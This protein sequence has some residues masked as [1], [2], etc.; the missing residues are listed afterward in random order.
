MNNFMVKLKGNERL[1]NDIESVFIKNFYIQNNYEDELNEKKKNI[2]YIL[3]ESYVNEYIIP[4]LIKEEGDYYYVLCEINLSSFNE[5]SDHSFNNILNLEFYSSHIYFEDIEK[6]LYKIKTNVQNKKYKEFNIKNKNVLLLHGDFNYINNNKVMKK[7]GNKMKELYNYIKENEHNLSDCFNNMEGSFILIYVQYENDKVN[8]IFFND[9]F[10]KKSFMFFHLNNSIVLT[11]MYGHFINYDFN[12]IRLNKENYLFDHNSIKEEFNLISHSDII[13]KK[14]FTNDKII[15][16]YENIKVKDKNINSI[17]EQIAINIRPHFIYNLLIQKDKVILKNIKKTNCI[18]NNYYEWNNKNISLKE[19]FQYILNFFEKNNFFDGFNKEEQ[20]YL[21][22]TIEY[23]VNE[24][25]KYEKVD[26]EKKKRY[27]NNENIFLET[28]INNIF[29]NLHMALLNNVIKK[30]I[31]ELFECTGENEIDK[32]K[33]DESMDYFFKK[34]I[35]EN[36]KEDEKKKSVGILFSGGIDSTLLTIITIKNFFRFY[37]NGYIELINVAF[38]ENAVD[39]Y[40]SLLS[41]EKIINLFPYYDIRLVFIDVSPDELIKYE[42]IIYSLIS[43]NNTTMDYNISSALF[44]ANIGRGYICPPSFFKS[45]VWNT[46]KKSIFHIFN[47]NLSKQMNKNNLKENN[48]KYHKEK[49]ENEE[50]KTKNI[51]KKCSVCEFVMNKNCIHKCCSSCCR[52]LRYIYLN[53]F[54][55]KKKQNIEKEIFSTFSKDVIN[56]DMNFFKE[57]KNSIDIYEVK[58]DKKTNKKFIYL[59]IKK[60]KILIDFEIFSECNIHKEKLYDYKKIGTLFFEFN[61]ELEEKKKHGKNKFKTDLNNDNKKSE[62]EDEEENVMNLKENDDNRIL[63]NVGINKIGKDNFIEYFVSK[64]SDQNMNDFHKI[65]N[66]FSV[67]NK[68]KKGENSNNKNKDKIFFDDTFKKEEECLNFLNRKL[69]NHDNR[70]NKENYECNHKLLI[71]GSGAD[72][73]YGGY[74]RQNNS[75]T[76]ISLDANFKMKEMIKDIKRLWIRN[77]YRDDRILSFTSI[78]RKDIFYPFLN[79]NLVNFLFLLSFYIIES[80]IHNLDSLEKIQDDEKE[81][82]QLLNITDIF[83]INRK[84]ENVEIKNENKLYKKN[85][86]F[87]M[88]NL[89]ECYQIY[90]IIRKHKISKWIL[91]MSI[92]FLKIKE[93]MFFKKKAIQFGSKAKNIKKYMK[94]SLYHFNNKEEI[95]YNRN[96]KK[97]DDYYTLLS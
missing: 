79:I 53:E 28:K 85:F 67:K 35:N 4:F 14:S 1:N 80:P 65:E 6:C 38:N 69:Y 16:S 57:E 11:N 52:K 74:Y 10:G 58:Y 63:N 82:S 25:M 71:I 18:Y 50:N 91:R 90:E 29:I 27:V 31:E 43:P 68:K 92:F 62:I 40:T 37:K 73:L 32:N 61:K 20:I 8:F 17:N 72:E 97:G 47:I 3:T 86:H 49:D 94:E 78:S 39:R 76:D 26:Y 77:L 84:I 7:D 87:L 89:E 48:E 45:N 66:L 54:S 96:D 81:E 93:V 2:K 88:E 95:I 9:Q 30:K 24:K 55:L 51:K 41:Y 34:N 70:E 83:Q 23:L 64:K 56:N 42:K 12:F 19:N 21:K 46:M 13:H 5:K 44:F 15:L 59:L 33:A 36:L 60:K 22:E 75:N